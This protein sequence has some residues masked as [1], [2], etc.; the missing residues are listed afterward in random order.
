MRRQSGLIEQRPVIEIQFQAQLLAANDASYAP[1][2]VY[3]AAEGSRP[4]VIG[5]AL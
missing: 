2:E 5:R 3:G 4:A 1:G